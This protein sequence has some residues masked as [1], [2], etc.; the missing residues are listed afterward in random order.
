MLHHDLRLGLQQYVQQQNRPSHPLTPVK[1]NLPYLC[2]L[3]GEGK[4]IETGIVLQ[5]PR[6]T[7][8]YVLYLL[9]PARVWHDQHLPPSSGHAYFHRKIRKKTV[10]SL[11]DKISA[12]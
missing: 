9:L 11:K 7:Y 1:A 3:R 8:F 6:F 5:F 4:K 10:I 2:D 12:P